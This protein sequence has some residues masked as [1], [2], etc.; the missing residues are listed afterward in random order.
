MKETDKKQEG[1]F[2]FCNEETEVIY[3]GR[4]TSLD[5]IIRTT[6]SKLKITSFTINHFRWNTTSMDLV[7]TT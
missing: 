5:S 1:V 7:R 2:E 4:S 6:K 3:F